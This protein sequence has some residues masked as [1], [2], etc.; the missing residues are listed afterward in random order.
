MNEKITFYYVNAHSPHE[1]ELVLYSTSKE[2]LLAGKG[3]PMILRE[4]KARCEA[5]GFELEEI[6][7]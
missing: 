4:L 1:K 5:K 3:T 6:K 7:I 2:S